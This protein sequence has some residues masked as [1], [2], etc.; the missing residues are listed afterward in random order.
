MTLQST[1]HSWLTAEDHA[2]AAAIIPSRTRI[3]QIVKEV[4]EASGVPMFAILG[5]SRMA[6]NVQA[7]RLV[8][9]IARREGFT[10][11]EIARATGHDHTSVM[12]GVRR[13]EQARR[14]EAQA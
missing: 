7:R 1:I 4:S 13:E 8:W 10:F 12:H 5:Q 3:R 6:E 2:R 14:A 9:F 11:Q